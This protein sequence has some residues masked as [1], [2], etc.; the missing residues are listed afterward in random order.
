MSQRILVVEDD[1][2]INELIS[3]NL[4]KEGFEVRSL[5]RGDEVR[6]AVTDFAPDLIL[7]DLM[8][9][10]VHGLEVCRLL[11]QDQASRH[12]PIVMVTAKGTE[13]DVVSGLQSGADDY[14]PK[15][16]S[17]KVLSARVA[18]VL[19]RSGQKGGHPDRRDFGI[20]SMDLLKR[21]VT[22]GGELAPLTT[23]EF[24]ILEFLSRSPG[25]VFTREQ[26]LD[27]VW[28]EGKFIVD[29]AVDVHI[30]GVRKKLGPADDMIETIR[31]VGYRFKDLE[32]L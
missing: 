8:L 28:K 25:R 12:I 1:V 15:P 6:G 4:K 2:S 5:L 7:L 23:L 9:P 32:D 21:R 20:L 14:I 11:K 10:G 18:A 22:V 19:R 3:Y 27:S 17:P 30:R 31:G 16:F 24:N 13:F 26:L 29:R